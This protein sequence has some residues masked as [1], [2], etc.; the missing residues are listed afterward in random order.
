MNITVH[1]RPS[2]SWGTLGLLA[3]DGEPELFTLEDVVRDGPKIAH[4]TAIPAGKYRVIIDRSQR[5]QRMLPRLLNVPGFSG[6]RIHPGNVAADTS[7]CLLVG[8]GYY[9][10]GVTRSRDAMDR[11]QPQIASALARGEDVWIVLQ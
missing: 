1:R 9:D 6:V 10:G 11:L 3:V 7:G 2:K 8:L 5:F 4:E